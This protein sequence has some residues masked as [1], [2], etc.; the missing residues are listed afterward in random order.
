MV[1][2]VKSS[3]KRIL[4]KKL[5]AWLNEIKF[6]EGEG[7]YVYPTKDRFL[8]VV[9]LPDGSY[10]EDQINHPRLKSEAC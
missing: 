10:R 4:R 6:N 7:F 8:I 2:K 5:T 3:L 9:H 1:N